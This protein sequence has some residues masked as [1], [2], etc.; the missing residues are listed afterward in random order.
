MKRPQRGSSDI[1]A[2]MVGFIFTVIICVVWYLI[3]GP[4]SCHA[5]FDST[6]RT[7]WGPIQ[8]CMIEVKRGKWI[9]AE[10]YREQD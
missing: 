5:K 1:G 10:N 8:G 3:A 4:L 6:F 9:P 2:E 7:T